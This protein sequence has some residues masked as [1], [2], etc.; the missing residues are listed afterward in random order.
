MIDTTEEK[1]CTD[2]GKMLSI[3]LFQARQNVCT[4]CRSI[5][6]IMSTMGQR[7]NESEW[8]ARIKAKNP[9]EWKKFKTAVSKAEKNNR[10]QRVFDIL[11]Y[12]E[13][14]YAR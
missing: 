5:D 9:K 6:R 10:G 8:L 12:K 2:F 7:Q 14:M 1:L 11:Q 13:K 3:T 4:E